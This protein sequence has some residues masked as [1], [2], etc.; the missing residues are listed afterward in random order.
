M[1]RVVYLLTHKRNPAPAKSGSIFHAPITC[2]CWPKTFVFQ[3]TGTGNLELL[4][5]LSEIRHP[6]SFFNS[7]LLPASGLPNFH[8]KVHVRKDWC[9]CLA[10]IVFCTYLYNL[11]WKFLLVFSCEMCPSDG[12]SLMFEGYFEKAETR[13]CEQLVVMLC[14]ISISNILLLIR[15]KWICPKFLAQ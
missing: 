12:R 3:P 15:M 11:D 7:F 4:W 8:H 1:L 9:F 14:L 10:V 6:D 2:Q 13:G 5:P